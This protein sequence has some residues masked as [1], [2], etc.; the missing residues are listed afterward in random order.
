MDERFL[1][2]L[3]VAVVLVVTPGPDT[4]LVTRNAVRGGARDASLTALG[5]TLGIVTWGT[6]SAAGLAAV[7]AASATA[8][9]VV[10]VAGAVVLV[11]LGL[12]S[13]RQV[14]QAGAARSP[15]LRPRGEGVPGAARAA[16][17]FVQGLAGNLLNPKAGA[18]FLS[19]VPQ[20]VRPGD[21]ALR[22][23]VMVV[24][25]GLMV[26]A[27]L[28][29]YGWLVSRARLRFGDRLRRA[30]DGLT[31]AVLVGLGLRLATESPQ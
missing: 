2:F 6:A 27:W 20:F 24:A 12:R 25:F 7:L 8:Y 28:H 11:V 13:L 23:A 19:V 4:A 26:C 31:G 1:A 17:A 15:S 30:L 10:R 22:L 14:V 21:P 18:I 16:P 9:T 5:V 3:A 29:L